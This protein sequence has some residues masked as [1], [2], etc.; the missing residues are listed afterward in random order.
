MA[1]GNLEC[2]PKLAGNFYRLHLASF[3]QFRWC[4]L[5][6]NSPGHSHFTV[7]L[8]SLSNKRPPAVLT[9]QVCLGKKKLGVFGQFQELLEVFETGYFLN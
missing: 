6:D 1:T 2:T 9:A 8:V 5:L 3:G 7:S 4:E